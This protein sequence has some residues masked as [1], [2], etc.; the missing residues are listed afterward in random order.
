MDVNAARLLGLAALDENGGTNS[1][2]YSTPFWKAFGGISLTSVTCHACGH[3]A[4]QYEMWHC[5]SLALSAQCITI[6]ALLASSWGREPLQDEDDKCEEPGCLVHRRRSQETRLVRW[7]N[8][9]AIHLKRWKV[10]SMVPFYQEKVPTRVTFE[11]VLLVESGRAPYHLRGVV[12]HEGVAGGGHYTAFVRA[13]DN[14]WY[15]CN[16]GRPPRLAPVGEVLQAEAYMLF[17]EQ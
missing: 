11:N 10:I 8:I 15:F 12:V 16:D 1:C 7:P 13:P 9:L 4:A 14:F 17:Y 5:L 3:T 2:R 6:E